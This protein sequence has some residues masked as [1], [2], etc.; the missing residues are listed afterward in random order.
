MGAYY[1]PEISLLVCKC[2]GKF[3]EIACFEKD[4]RNISNFICSDCQS[5]IRKEKMK[6][7]KDS[8]KK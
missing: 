2:C 3:K 4:F 1:S 6:A 8:L 5:K 7:I